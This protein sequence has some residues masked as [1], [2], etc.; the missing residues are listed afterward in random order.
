MSRSAMPLHYSS[1]RNTGDLLLA[2]YSGPSMNPTLRE[3]EMVEIMPYGSL[4][5]R[6]GDVVY[7]MPQ[8]TDQPIIHRVV[9]VTSAGIF[10]RGDNNTREDAFILQPNN[11]RG[12]V[13][14]AWNGQ[15]RR[16]IAGGWTGCLIRR[17]I[18]WHRILDHGV[19]PLLHPL[20]QL[21]SHRG[22]LAR[23]LPSRFRPRI[24]VFHTRDRDQFQLLIGKRVIGR[25]DESRHQ[26]QIRRPFH[27]L[28]DAKMLPGRQPD[29]DPL[30][31]PVLTERQ[32]TVNH[33]QSQKVLCHLALADGNHW[34][35]AAGDEDAAAIVSQLGCAMQLR[36]H[37]DASE[38]VERGRTFRLLVQVN[39]AVGDCYVPLASKNN[40]VAV[41]NLYS[42]ERQG[43]P[44]F[45]FTRLSLVFAREAQ[46]CGGILIHGALAEKDGMGVILAAPGGTGKTTASDRL[47]FPWKSLCDDTTLVV[48]DPQG[49]YLAHPWPTWSRF[50]NG[51][52]GGTWDVQKA[53]PLRAVFVLAQANEDRAEAI[54]PGHAVSLLSECVRQASQFMPWGLFREE[55][56]ALHLERFN[57][58][59]AL[60]RVIP[61]HV[62]HIRLR[63]AFWKEIEQVLEGRAG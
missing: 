40:G 59:C 62:L 12:R 50:Q 5:V 51:G 43:E 41:V 10:T 42:C 14:A 20:Y 45:N 26:W 52:A 36:L 58:L 25:Y 6:A 54:G 49:V 39:A 32:R 18:R 53:V 17:R 37:S 4:P 63:G 55:V 22:W 21:L 56:H 16:T 9:R 27:L 2:A 11:I 57:N 46:A 3:P 60:V 48:R 35:I 15:R 8:D 33:P 23:L 61:A 34:E 19:S 44:H 7:F 13:V 28:I 1:G 47:P 24:V 29:K 31:R 30:P 38:N